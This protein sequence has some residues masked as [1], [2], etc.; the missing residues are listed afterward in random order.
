MKQAR[1]GA[2]LSEAQFELAR[3]YGVASWPRLTLV[4]RMVDAIWRDDVERVR[5]LVTKHPHLLHEMARG[6]KEC[7]WGPPMSYAAN[8]GRDRIIA[9][10]RALGATDLTRAIDRAVL[11]GQIE[12]ARRLYAMGAR[13]ERGCVMGPCE[14]Q[15]GEGLAYLL[16]LGAELCDRLGDRSAPLAMLLGTYCRNSHGKHECLDLLARHGVALADTP[17]MAVHRGRIDL[18]ERHLQTDPDLVRRTFSLEEIYPECGDYDANGNALGIHGTPLEGTSLCT[19]A[20]TRTS[21]RSFSG[22]SSTAPTRT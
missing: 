11:Q 20:W 18:L 13:L 12:T 22:S 7:N 4:C 15:S 14:T 9:T 8:L 21:P 3:E 17:T 16:E 19:S 10:L 1:P 5:T 6:T 2:R